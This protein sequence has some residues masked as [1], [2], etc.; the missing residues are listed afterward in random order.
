MRKKHQLILVLARRIVIVIVTATAIVTA[1]AI[2]IVIA[3]AIVQNLRAAK[4]PPRLNPQQRLKLLL[5]KL[6]LQ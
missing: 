4:K 5:L 2:V 1:I 3:I 6:P